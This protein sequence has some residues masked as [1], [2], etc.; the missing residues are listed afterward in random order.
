MHEHAGFAAGRLAGVK[1]D[2]MP[3]PPALWELFESFLRLG[4]T[5]FGGPS[6]VAYIRQMAVEERRW[7]EAGDYDDGVALCQMIPGATAMQSAAYVGL[8][9]R[10]IAG[11]AIAFVG[12]GL[13]AFVLMMTLSWLY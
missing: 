10:G 9:L 1:A 3:A 8:R 2:P 12:F 11:A 4:L 13:P 6:M 7:L 5:A